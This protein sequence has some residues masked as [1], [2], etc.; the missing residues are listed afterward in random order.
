M[1]RCLLVALGIA[2]LS[3]GRLCLL[4]PSAEPSQGE[5]TVQQIWD[6]VHLLRL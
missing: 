6:G 2:F 1:V 4:C 5:E 3:S